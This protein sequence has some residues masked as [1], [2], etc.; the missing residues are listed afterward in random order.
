MT[1]VFVLMPFDKEFDP[2]E[3]ER[4]VKR[5]LEEAGLTFSRADNIQRVNEYSEG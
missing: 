5:V 1:S 2:V 3:Y 4:F